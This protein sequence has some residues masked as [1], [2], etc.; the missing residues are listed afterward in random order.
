MRLIRAFSRQL[1]AFG[2]RDVMYIH[3]KGTN[4]RV[5]IVGLMFCAVFVLVSFFARR[6]SETDRAL[7]KADRLMLIAGKPPPPN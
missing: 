4:R 1:N 7:V 3:D 5:M 2:Y 6:Q